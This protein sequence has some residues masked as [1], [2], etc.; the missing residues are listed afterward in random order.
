[1]NMDNDLRRWMRLVEAERTP[2]FFYHG[3]NIAAACMIM[4]DD[5]IK[6]DNPVDDADMGAVVCVT[7]RKSI[8]RL[9]AVEFAR[10]N[11]EYPVG[12]IFTLDARKILTDL[13]GIRHS[14]ETQ[15]SEE[16]AEYRIQGNLPIKQYCLK[17]N[18]V[19]KTRKIQSRTL[20]NEIYDDWSQY[21]NGRDHFFMLRQK[22]LQAAGVADKLNDDDDDDYI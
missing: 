15:G 21:F 11:S 17:I 22:L 13:R 4:R 6:A 16:E 20:M 2:R 18:L 1:M 12:V 9:F 19:G 3:T 7:G 5:A 10:V 8:A 14:A